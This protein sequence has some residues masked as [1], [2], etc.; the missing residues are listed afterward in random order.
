MPSWFASD[1]IIFTDGFRNIWIYF[2][3]GIGYG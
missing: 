2:D 1:M 3:D